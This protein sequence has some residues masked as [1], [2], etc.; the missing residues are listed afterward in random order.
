MLSHQELL[1]VPLLQKIQCSLIFWIA[2]GHVSEQIR[3][4]E[5]EEIIT[6]KGMHWNCCL[7]RSTMSSVFWQAVREKADHKAA[8]EDI[9]STEE[10]KTSSASDFLIDS[11]PDEIK[12]SDGCRSTP[13]HCPTVD[14]RTGH[15]I[16]VYRQPCGHQSIL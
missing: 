14:S 13:C 5:I 7:A 10:N 9:I 11:F 3:R 4:V 6:K 8:L 1:G 16:S 15:P 12:R 2:S